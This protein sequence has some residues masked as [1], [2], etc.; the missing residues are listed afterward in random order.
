MRLRSILYLFPIFL[1]FLLLI[2]ICIDFSDRNDLRKGPSFPISRQNVDY[3]DD[4]LIVM[5]VKN[6]EDAEIEYSIALNSVRCYAK[7]QKYTFE[8]IESS[9]FDKICT[10]SD[11]MFQRHCIVAEVL[12]SS[13]KDWVLFLD[14]DMAVVN[15]NVRI[16]EYLST[17]D[18][19]FYD[20]FVNWEIAAGSYIVRNSQ[21]SYDFLRKFADFEN[22]L[23]TNSFHG[24]D[25]GAIHVYIQQLFYPNLSENAKICMRIWEKSRGFDDLYTFEACIRAIMGESREFGDGK[26]RILGKGSGW[27][28]D[29][30]LSDS[31]WSQQRDFMLHGLKKENRIPWSQGYLTNFV[32]SN[33]NW[34]SP[35]KS[36]FDLEKCETNTEN[37]KLKYDSNL[38]VSSTKIE[39][40][41][42]R[43]YVE[44]EKKR[45]KF[46]SFVSDY[47]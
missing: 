22:F 35:F 7:M 3:K 11:F 40:Y 44:I 8:L 1:L 46:M 31:E 4:I 17:H 10:Q 37:W 19:T 30:W 6:L 39:R 12:K 24:T 9:N 16:E 26:L 29:I 15:P 36:S 25:N 5:V 34:R 47:L 13:G 43:K 42:E 33:F 21:Y 41:L 2:V 32:F 38:I 45:W 14:A 27:V 20:R 28:R 23:P 18:L